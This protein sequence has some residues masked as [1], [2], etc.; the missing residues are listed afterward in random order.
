MKMKGHDM[1]R[2]SFSERRRQ[3]LA[4][5]TVGAGA[6]A[7]PA[8]VMAAHAPM[9]QFS[10]GKM[11]VSGRVIG[12]P[13]GKPLS[14]AQIE[15]WPVDARGVRSETA[16]EVIT[17]D[18]DGRYFATLK[19]NAQRVHYRVSHKGYTTKVAQVN[20]AAQ[21]RAVTLTRDDA[22][23]TR[24]AFEMKLAPGNAVATSGPDALAL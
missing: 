2:E 16:H 11:V 23:V 24:A 14:G 3:I 19:G 10:N 18:G 1:K 12:A 9:V 7:V 22:G 13:D 5:G 15:I 21:Q 6:L 4:L 8:A 17:A 20:C